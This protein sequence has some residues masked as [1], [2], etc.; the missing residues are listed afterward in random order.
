MAQGRAARAR[1]ADPRDTGGSRPVRQAPKER[2]MNSR[3]VMV[4]AALLF[5]S[6]P[7][8]ADIYRW[9]DETGRTQFGD[10]VPDRY[11]DSA[12]KLENP[13]L[14]TDR[15]RSEGAARAAKERSAAA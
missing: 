12:R 5:C 15:Q 8:A 14:P 9:V 10:S 2:M 13:P 4:V 6:M 11:K 3:L 1:R 7:R